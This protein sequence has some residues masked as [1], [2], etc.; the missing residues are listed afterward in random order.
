MNANS[1]IVTLGDSVSWGQGLLP[2]HKFANLVAATFGASTSGNNF[3]MAHSGAI[4][5]ATKPGTTTSTNPEIPAPSPMIIDQVSQV[6][7]PETADL[8]LVMGGINDVN[9][10]TIF[11]PF[12]PLADLHNATN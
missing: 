4:I 8:V 10:T 1:R 11:D 2:Q 3:M 5:G 7:A 9:I 6:Q 12:T